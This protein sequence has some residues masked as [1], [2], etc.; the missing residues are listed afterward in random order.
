[1]SLSALSR[2]VLAFFLAAALQALAAPRAH[3]QPAAEGLPAVEDVLA[4]HVRARGGLERLKAVQAIR[5]TGTMT[6]PAGESVPTTIVMQRPDR[7]RQE[8]QVQG[9][10][11]VQAFDGTRGW[12]LNPMMGAAPVTVP[13]AVAQRMAE[14]A[15]FDGPLVEPAGKGHRVEVVGLERVGDRPAV[16]LKLTRKSGELQWIWL[17]GERWLELKS[18]ATVDQAGRRVRIESRNSEFRTVDG[19]TTPHAVEVF[20]DGQ[21][22]QRIVVERVEFP[23]E[24]DSRL[25]EP[26]S[27]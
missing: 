26:P 15:D 5:L 11:L 10:T 21:L 14:Q 18:E 6:G 7:I 2:I 3:A 20:A 23:R 22:Q 27:R 12:T 19:I 13:R 1:M 4:N 24:I 9:E 25:F 16:K 17:D 8:I